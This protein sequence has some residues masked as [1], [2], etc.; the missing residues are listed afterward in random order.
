MKPFPPGPGI[1]ARAHQRMK[2]VLRK[3]KEGKTLEWIGRQLQVTRE[4][5]RQIEGLAKHLRT[6]RKL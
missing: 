5:V 6:L 3:R 2:Y 4:R 1:T